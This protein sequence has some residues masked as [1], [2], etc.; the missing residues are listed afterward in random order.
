MKLTD[1]LKEA[2]NGSCDSFPLWLHESGK[3]PHVVG[4]AYHVPADKIEWLSRGD[5]TAEHDYVVLLN[6]DVD[7]KL[8]PYEMNARGTGYN[9]NLFSGA[10]EGDFDSKKEQAD[11]AG[12][13]TRVF[14]YHEP[15]KA[16]R[17]T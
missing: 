13:F 1:V 10:F 15:V 7:G 16:S 6:G 5:V 17:S 4:R 14:G 9:G 2:I 11:I 8:V 3:K 12:M